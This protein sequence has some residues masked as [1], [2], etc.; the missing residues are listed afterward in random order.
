MGCRHYTVPLFSSTF[1]Y[2]SIHPFPQWP[3]KS[4]VPVCCS[5]TLQFPW[6]VSSQPLGQP[7]PA[8]SLW[9]WHLEAARVLTF[10][11]LREGDWS[12]CV[13]PL[14][15]TGSFPSSSSSYLHHFPF[16]HFF[17]FLST[18]ESTLWRDIL[19]QF[20]YLLVFAF[21]YH[22]PPVPILTLTSYNETITCEFPTSSAPT[23]Y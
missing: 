18:L 17:S 10:L 15:I 13:P 3:M 20:P 4:R 1:S 19:Q 12:R 23:L 22:L 9:P 8:G 7:V 21:S 2:L 5:W 16:L 11:D 14:R 6:H